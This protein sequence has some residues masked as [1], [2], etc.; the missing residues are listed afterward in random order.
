[1]NS[2]L[3]K[4]CWVEKYCIWLTDQLTSWSTVLPEKLTG[5][6]LVKKFPAFYGTWRFIAMFTSICHLSLSQTRAIQSMLLHPTSLRAVLL[7]YSHLCQIFQVVS[8]PQVSP[9]KPC[10]HLS[11]LPYALRALP[12]SFFLIWSPEWCLVRIIFVFTPLNQ[13]QLKPIEHVR[14][15][16]VRADEL[17]TDRFNWILYLCYVISKEHIEY[18]H[19]FHSKVRIETLT[20]LR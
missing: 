4:K 1:M 11:C 19:E 7:V 20:P 9:P 15:S 10:M 5:P 3:C 2:D 14:N 16:N 17:R 6:Q 13:I 12:I 8:L 18:C